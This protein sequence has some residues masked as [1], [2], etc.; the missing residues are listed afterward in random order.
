VRFGARLVLGAG[1]AVLLVACPKD[2]TPR[3]S[4]LRVP[5]PPG[6]VAEEGKSGS[7]KAGPRGRTVLVLEHQG[8][9][10]LPGPEALE[11]AVKEEGAEVLDVKRETDVALVRY[12]V[13]AGAERAQAFIGARRLEG[14]LFLCASAPEVS[15]AELRVAEGVCRDL[16]WG[17]VAQ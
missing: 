12:R 2:E 8:E 17:G 9:A 14:R 1:A 16:K 15:E 6:W 10:A 13:G 3:P 5:L 7:L 11:D 4:G